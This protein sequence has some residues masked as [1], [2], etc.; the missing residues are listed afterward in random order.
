LALWLQ[1]VPA[2]EVAKTKTRMTFD[3]F[4]KSSVTKLIK[5]LT[6]LAKPVRQQRV[7]LILDEAAIF[8][9]QPG[10]LALSHMV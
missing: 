10:V 2:S 3:S 7:L 9:A 1:A 4:I 6:L 8:A 5:K